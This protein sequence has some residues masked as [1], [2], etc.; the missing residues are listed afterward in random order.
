MLA[1][2]SISNADKLNLQLES[3]LKDLPVWTVHLEISRRGEE[4]AALFDEE[5]LLP[6]IILTKNQ[7]YQGMISRRVFFEQM[8]RPYGLGL[9]AGRPAQNLYNFLKPEVTVFADNKTIVEA[10]QIALRQWPKNTYE[11]ILIKTKS[12]KYGLI[13]FQHLLLAYSQIQVFTLARLQQEEEDARVAKA[14]FLDLQHSYTRSVQNEKM[15]A[16]GQ[17]VAGIAHEINNPINFIYGNLSHATQYVED[18]FHL[19]QCYQEQYPDAKIPPEANMD[20][21]DI[22]FIKE[23]LPKLISSMM[24]G[25]S[26]IQEIVLSLRNFSRLDEADIKIVDI[27]EGIDNTL[28]ILKNRL[29]SQPGRPEIKVIK[30]Y[31]TLPRVECYAGQLNQVFM[32]ILNNSIDALTETYQVSGCPGNFKTANSRHLTIRIITEVRDNQQIIIRI[33]DNGMGIPEDI[34]KRLFDPFF[35]TKTVGKG[36]GLGLSISYQIVVEKHG[37]QLYCA[38]APGKGAEFIIKIPVKLT[39]N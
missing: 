17:L 16:L 24:T 25:A 36:T 20:V 4:L 7:Q 34:Q 26:R 18:L 11:P 19:L 23:D 10:T 32:N 35:T 27:H 38:S 31:G 13:D 5:P 30:E 12:F 14:G 22:D 2:H 6:G 29:K 39:S 9:F 21:A 3:T 37:G 28:I 8:S 33:A 15:V 1:M